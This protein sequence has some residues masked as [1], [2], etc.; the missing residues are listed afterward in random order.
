MRGHPRASLLERSASI[1]LPGTPNTGPHGWPIAFGQREAQAAIVTI[2]AQSVTV[3]PLRIRRAIGRS[4]VCAGVR[5][6]FKHNV[7]M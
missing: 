5:A 6:I 3:A 2:H 4:A 7:L 1:G